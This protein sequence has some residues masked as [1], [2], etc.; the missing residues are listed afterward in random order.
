L[1]KLRVNKGLLIPVLTPPPHPAYVINVDDVKSNGF[2]TFR[3]CEMYLKYNE[4]SQT[5][6]SA[7]DVKNIHL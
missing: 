7:G 1:V 6:V 5:I 2:E 3:G 4:P